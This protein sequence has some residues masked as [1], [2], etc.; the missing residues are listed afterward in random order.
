MGIQDFGSVPYMVSPNEC[1]MHIMEPMFTK[2]ANAKA[3]V[4]FRALSQGLREYVCDIAKC[5]DS[6]VMMDTK[7]KAL[8]QIL[9][10][11]ITGLASIRALPQIFISD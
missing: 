3:A 9:P 8:D 10:V 1:L 2:R 7:K 5:L 6:Y 4:C 11:L